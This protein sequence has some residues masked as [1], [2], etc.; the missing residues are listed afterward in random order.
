M[1]NM[2]MNLLLLVESIV[3]TRAAGIILVQV[4]SA[5]DMIIQ[6][7]NSKE[8]VKTCCIIELLN[9]CKGTM[10]NSNQ[11]ISVFVEKIN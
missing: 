9:F 11:F 1:P 8:P 10:D 6:H 7:N 4:M 3:I 2:D 5:V